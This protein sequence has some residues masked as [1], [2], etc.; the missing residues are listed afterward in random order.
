MEGPDWIVLWCKDKSMV[1][2]ECVV[3]PSSHFPQP[4]C[5]WTITCFVSLSLPSMDV[6]LVYFICGEC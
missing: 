4:G 3:D 1:V 5:G 2:Y 6:A